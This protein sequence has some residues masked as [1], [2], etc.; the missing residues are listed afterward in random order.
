MFK[1]IARSISS[2][3]VF[4]ACLLAL[5]TFLVPPF[6]K[7]DEPVH[8]Y[9]TMALTHGTYA[10]G[11]DE[12]SS[13]FPI[14]ESVFSFPGKMHWNAIIMRPDTKFPVGVYKNQ[15]PFLKDS[16][17]SGRSSYCSLPI[18]PYIPQVIGAFLSFPF[19]NLLITFYMMRL[20]SVVFFLFF[21]VLS[22]RILSLQYRKLFFWYASIPM[23]TH[24]VTAV[25]YDAVALS[26]MLFLVSLFL[27]YLHKKTI[28][29]MQVVW[30]SILFVLTYMSKKGY[31]SLAVL[32]LI[33]FLRLPVCIQRKRVLVKI[34][35]GGILGLLLLSLTPLRDSVLKL[36]TSLQHQL[37]VRDPFYFIT[38]LGRTLWEDQGV[39]IAGLFGTFGWLEYGLPATV[40]I[41]FMIIGVYVVYDLYGKDKH[42]LTFVEAILILF[43]ITSNVVLLFYHFYLHETPFAYRIIFGFQGRYLLPLVPLFL[44]ALVRLL[45]CI[46]T[47][48]WKRICRVCFSIGCIVAIFAV[49]YTRYYDFSK[50]FSNPD[51]LKNA[52]EKNILDISV[53]G[54]IPIRDTKEYIYEVNYPHYKIAGFQMLI[55]NEQSIGV[56]Y[57]FFIKDRMCQ[58]VLQNGYVDSIVNE[59]KKFLRREQ[60]IV[61][62]QYFP[63]TEL[64]EPSV[65]LTFRPIFPPKE[66]TELTLLG[67]TKPL[68]QFLYIAQ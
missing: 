59:S 49:V 35:I 47:Q 45:S 33:L 51:Q 61:Y 4:I 31:V 68:I 62:T 20:S 27:S 10:C 12:I 50:S 29:A 46:N 2:P 28:T 36:S 25:S 67:D 13:F 6:Q 14:S 21:L 38:V 23:L 52:V 22:Y 57:Q 8:F 34:F 7:P 44:V 30:V 19:N 32:P 66:G 42:I 41:G 1:K 54:R 58:K 15:Y 37:V 40:T 63:I 17:W 24:Q 39:L 9:W 53:L 64:D 43:S 5:F 65:C 55:E 3:F 11:D 56:P 18:L 48:N 60:E 26:L 16:N